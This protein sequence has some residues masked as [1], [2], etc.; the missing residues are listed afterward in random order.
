MARRAHRRSIGNWI[1]PPRFLLFV[2]VTAAAIYLALP[3][4]GLRFGIMAGFDAGALVFF[5][6]CLSL[7]G[8]KSER[9]RISACRNDANRVFLLLITGAVML[10]ILVSIASELRQKGAAS[11]WLLALIIGTLAIAWTFSNFIY[12]LHYAHLFYSEHEGGD[13]G[14]LQFPGTSEPDYWDFI[15]FAFCLGM[16]F[17]TSDVT[18]TDGGMRR[19]VTLHC[20]EAFVF[21]LGVIA[22]TINVLGGG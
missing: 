2:A 12:A 7:L 1:A 16:T 18:V 20:L 6:S 19:T 14:G 8:H 4:L 10:V 15:Y 9:M 22:F 3:P 5:A 11:P 21:N 17:Q 13:A